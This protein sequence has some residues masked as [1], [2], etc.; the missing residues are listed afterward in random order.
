MNIL[1]I[2]CNINCRPDGS[3]HRSQVYGIGMDI[4]ENCV[5]AR[6]TTCL[7]DGIQFS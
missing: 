4:Y 2:Y 1:T 6:D 5:T 3:S 7:A